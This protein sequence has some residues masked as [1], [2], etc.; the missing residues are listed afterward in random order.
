M[1]DGLH[2]VGEQTGGDA[3]AV[4]VAVAME[5]DREGGCWHTVAMDSDTVSH[6]MD[7]E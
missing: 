6:R 2:P 5:A 1:I 4:P 3:G 7:C